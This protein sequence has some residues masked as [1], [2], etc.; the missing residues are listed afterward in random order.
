MNDIDV[1]AYKAGVRK[2]LDE[3]SA[4]L[5][6]MWKAMGEHAEADIA[7]GKNVCLCGEKT[8]LIQMNTGM[9][10]CDKHAQDMWSKGIGGACMSF[11]RTAS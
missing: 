4:Q 1:E 2:M 7:A 9:W 3:M 5:D 10:V 11:E 6:P 8:L